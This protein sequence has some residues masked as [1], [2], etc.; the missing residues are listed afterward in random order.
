MRQPEA[1]KEQQELLKQP[2][3]DDS[4][5]GAVAKAVPRRKLPAIP[6]SAV[7]QSLA[8][9]NCRRCGKSSHPRQLCPAKDVLCYRCNRKG[10]YSSQCLSNTVAP[11]P[12]GVHELSRQSEQSEASDRYL[13]TVVGNKKNMWSITIRLQG[14]PIVVKVDTGAEVTAI[15][16]STWKSL[17]IWKPL[18]ETRISLCG[19]DNTNLKILAK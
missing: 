19:P 1:V 6:S 4:S 17:N 12:K 2:T 14:K 10:H 5:L 3:G 8:T 15:S 16:D 18:E 11:Q 7:Q 13:D 9:Q